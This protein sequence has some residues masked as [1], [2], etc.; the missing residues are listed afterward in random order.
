MAIYSGKD[1]SLEVDD[2]AVGRV[3]AWSIQASVDTLDVT[4]LGDIARSYTPGLKGATGSASLIYHDDN[5]E[6]QQILDDCITTGTPGEAKMELM[7]GAKKLEFNA[8]INSAN[9]TCSVG[10]VL[11]AEISFTMSGDYHV[12]T[13]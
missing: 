12:V 3:R 10:E 11:S 6:I 5:T 9:I 4:N 7:W 1:G 8:Y 13:L 2:L